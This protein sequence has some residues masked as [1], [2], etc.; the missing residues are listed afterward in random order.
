MYEDLI[1]CDGFGSFKGIIF[2][3]KS[4]NFSSDNNIDGLRDYCLDNAIFTRLPFN[5]IL[6]LLKFTNLIE[7]TE[8]KIYINKNGKELL[9]IIDDEK[10]SLLFAKL[11]LGKM[12]QDEN[13]HAFF[14]F[15]DIKYDSEIKENYISITDIPL[16]Y[17][18]IRNLLINIGFFRAISSRP[19]FIFLKGDNLKNLEEIR[20]KFK[21]R[22]SLQ[23]FKKNQEILDLYGNEAEEFVLSYERKRLSLN[24]FKDKIERISLLDVSA[25]FDIISFKNKNSLVCDRFIEVK[26]YSG[27]PS[28]YWSRNEVDLAKMR[29]EDYCIYLVNRDEMDKEDYS[30]HIIIN[31]YQNV[32][33]NTI[34]WSKEIVNWYFVSL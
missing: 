29:G 23:D 19:N 11:L 30:P 6:L 1:K 27:N 33:S 24:P 22:I 4:I 32:Y 26:S 17:S 7:L 18:N 2:V 12:I 9:S 20:E 5:S 25:G 10:T 21:K 34:N 13:F 8:K 15:L 31:P 14:E 28:F 16:K 3:L